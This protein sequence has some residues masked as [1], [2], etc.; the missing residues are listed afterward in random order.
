MRTVGPFTGQIVRTMDP[1]IGYIVRIIGPFIKAS[2][3]DPLT[4]HIVNSGTPIR[5]YMMESITGQ[6]VNV[7]KK[8]FEKHKNFHMCFESV[9]KSIKIFVCVLKECFKKLKKF[10]L[11]FERVF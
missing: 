5:A 1:L 4:R 6:Y 7:L 9:L 3:T 11:C 2:M 8:C 10:C